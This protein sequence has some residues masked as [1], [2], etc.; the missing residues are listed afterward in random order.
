MRITITA[1]GFTALAVVAIL[2]FIAVLS[3]DPVI[4]GAGIAIWLALALDLAHLSM[5]VARRP[6]RAGVERA[7]VRL[8]V[9]QRA[10]LRI[11]LACTSVEDVVIDSP[12][13]QTVRT[14]QSPRGYVVEAVIEPEYCGKHRVD[15]IRILQRSLLGLF[16]LTRIVRIDIEVAVLPR[17]WLLALVA[18]ALLQGRAAGIGSLGELTSAVSQLR[19]LSGV[20]YLS[21][22][23]QPGDPPIRIDWKATARLLKLIVKEFREESSGGMLFVLNERCLGPRT[24]DALASLLLSIAI[25]SYSS[26]TPLNIYIENRSTYL[27]L[28][29]SRALVFAIR[30]AFEM[31]IARDLDPYELLEPST[32]RELQRILSIRLPNRV[33][34]ELS[35]IVEVLGSGLR[36]V[37]ASTLVT[38]TRRDIEIADALRSRGIEVEV[39]T[40]SKPWLDLESLEDAYIVYRTYRLALEKLRKLGCILRVVGDNADERLAKL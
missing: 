20:Y 1:R 21:R 8:W 32:L 6:C 40:P 12:V 35:R 5:V 3:C 2:S 26:S 25:A 29:P 10:S 28:D 22:E 4:A 27:R 36:V 37:I 9:G 18:L 34:A 23:Y 15:E 24:C 7:S 11:P 19:S 16:L 38:D 17:A 13:I 30:R 33:E 31:E 14:R 39:Y